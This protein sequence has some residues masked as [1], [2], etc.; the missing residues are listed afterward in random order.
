MNYLNRMAYDTGGYTV[1]EILSSF[2]KKI[3]EII[4]LVNNNEL[5][6][7]EAR[8]LLTEI[9]ETLLPIEVE[10]ILNEFVDDGTIE[11]LINVNL[12]NQL[13]DDLTERMNFLEEKQ[14][15]RIFK[16]NFCVSSYWGESID[17]LGNITM[18][19]LD[20]VKED[21]I[22]WV[23]HKV[24]GVVLIFHCS[25]NELTNDLFLCQN[26]QLMREYAD[27]CIE[28]GL[29]IKALKT[30]IYNVTD[31]DITA[32]G[33]SNFKN[34]Y[35][36]YIKEVETTFNDLN[37]EYFVP[38]NEFVSFYGDSSNTSY[39]VSVL[40]YIKGLGYKTGISTMGLNECFNLLDDIKN[41]VD[42]FFVNHYQSISDK[43]EQTTNMDSIMSFNSSN[44]IQFASYF[45]NNFPG[46]EFIISETGV[47]DYW[48]ALKKPETSYGSERNNGIVQ[49]V[50]LNGVFSYLNS[51]LIDGVWWWFNL[52]HDTNVTVNTCQYFIGGLNNEFK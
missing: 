10:K 27:L 7:E 11:S 40:N 31:E 16:P 25:F 9:K 41:V 1:Q 13:K 22:S 8:N 47:N 51:D 45:K 38:F 49:D 17:R 50:Y 43:L 35:F 24:D 3:M 28:N 21:I 2:Y 29:T 30:H 32:M 26:L 5:T 14:K 19:S 34:S 18:N 48:E 42:V 15:A 4:D 12:F 39:I 20:Q 23:A 6:C 33:L 36:N 44:I 46:K 52:A 37:I